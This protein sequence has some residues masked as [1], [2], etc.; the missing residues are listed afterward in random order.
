[1]NTYQTI[2]IA[3]AVG[4]TGWF[5]GC[6][7]SSTTTAPRTTPTQSGLPEAVSEAAFLG[8]ETVKTVCASCHL[9][10]LAGAPK[11]GDQ[12]AWSVRVKKGFETLATH[13]LN[14]YEGTGGTVMPPRG[15]EP[16]LTD[17]EVKNAVHYFMEIHSDN[18]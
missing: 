8:R 16:S 3:A 13:A 11:I 12:E 4:I 18:R 15:G 5:T 14:G 9:P 17:E 6:G 10:G 2:V 7:E 1:M